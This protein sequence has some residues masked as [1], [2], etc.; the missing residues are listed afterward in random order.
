MGST[1]LSVM[2]PLSDLSKYV[3]MS[4]S[5]YGRINQSESNM[6]FYKSEGIK[7]IDQTESTLNV[8]L[9]QRRLVSHH[10]VD[11]WGAFYSN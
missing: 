7:E 10:V 4:F 8:I 6:T 9:L 11:L 1:F 5:F 2:I 3:K